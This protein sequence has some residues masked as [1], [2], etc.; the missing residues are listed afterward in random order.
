M[1]P[2]ITISYNNAINTIKKVLA[3]N[4]KRAKDKLGGMVYQDFTISAA[5]ENAC[6][7]YIQTAVNDVV[8]DALDIVQGLSRT[9][10]AITFRI[11]NTRWQ[12][13]INYAAMFTVYKIY[14][15]TNPQLIKEI[16][17]DANN[18]KIAIHEM[19]FYKCPPKLNNKDYSHV[20]A[21]VAPT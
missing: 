10:D 18:I 17:A 9:P 11:K 5:E 19:I 4:A 3:V 2:L 21:L 6:K 16:E 13:I 15:A 14:Q 1:N 8:V 7:V 12:H 20:S